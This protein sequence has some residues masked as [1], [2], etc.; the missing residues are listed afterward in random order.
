MKWP[1]RLLVFAIA[2]SLG[3]AAAWSGSLFTATFDV[4][5]LSEPVSRS[6]EEPTSAESPSGI[7]VAY[8]GLGSDSDGRLHL[9][10]IVHNGLYQP[11]SYSAHFADSPFAN[12]KANGKELMSFGRCGTGIRSFYI[13]PGR[14]AEFHVNQYEFSELP[15]EGSRISAGFYLKPT[16]SGESGRYYSEPFSLPDEFRKQ[17]VRY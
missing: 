14:S 12:L 5:D 10:F 6:E 11:V 1:G 13:L 17:I 16:V 4:P 15:N 8:A 7:T 2:V 3:T 9:K